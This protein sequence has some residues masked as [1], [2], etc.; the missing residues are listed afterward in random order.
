MTLLTRHRHPR[1]QAFSRALMRETQIRP[2]DFIYPVFIQEAEGTTPIPTLPGISRFGGKALLEHI[3]EA[4]ARGLQAVALFPEVPARQKSDDCREAWNA[5]NLIGRT[6]KAIKDHVPDLGLVCDVALDPYNPTGQDGYISATGEIENDRTVEA[7]VKQALCLA[8]AGADVIAPS[9]MMDGRIGAIRA[10]LEG[11]GFA[12]TILLSYAAKYASALYGPFRDAIG[13][14]DALKGDK[15]SYQMD[16]AN[17][18]EALREIQSDLNEGADWIMVKP[19][20]TYLD[21]IREAKS[22]F[23]V[24]TFAY[25]VSGE[26]AMWAFA[27]EAGALDRKTSIQEILLSCKRA[28]A[29]GIL[30]YAAFEV[31][32]WL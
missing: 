32:D 19:G 2:A 12:N 6:L 7:L 3:A 11:E 17:R 31:A 21:I 4:S 22:A 9:D 20:H 13:S 1:M 29:D 5:D 25:H 8:H 15:K 26:Y 28:G 16:P 24:P 14:S 30:T 18:A 23:E 10:A 27:A